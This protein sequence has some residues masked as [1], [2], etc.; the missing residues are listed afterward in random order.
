V[1]RARCALLVRLAEAGAEA[2]ALRGE[3]DALAARVATLERAASGRS[4]VGPSTIY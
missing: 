4:E 1:R 3:H 2:A